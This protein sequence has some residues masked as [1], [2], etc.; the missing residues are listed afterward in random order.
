[1]AAIRF[2]VDG[3]E[4][5]KL[6]LSNLF[7]DEA[8]LKSEAKQFYIDFKDVDEELAHWLISNIHSIHTS[9]SEVQHIKEEKKEPINRG[10]EKVS[11]P[12]VEPKAEQPKKASP[13]SK[14]AASESTT[15]RK[16]DN[17]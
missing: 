3:S 11:P 16:T 2:V 6:L 5:S 8:L 15:E 14:Q 10:A 17:K 12:P 1:M 7:H 4:R 13:V 9:I